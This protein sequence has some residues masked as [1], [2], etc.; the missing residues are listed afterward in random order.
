[1]LRSHQTR[2]EEDTFLGQETYSNGDLVVK[3]SNVWDVCHLTTLS[4]VEVANEQDEVIVLDCWSCLVHL[5]ARSVYQVS[6]VQGIYCL[7]SPVLESIS[8]RSRSVEFR[9]GIRQKMQLSLSVSRPIEEAKDGFTSHRIGMRTM[10]LEGIIRCCQHRKT[11]CK[12]NLHRLI[13]VGSC[14]TVAT[15]GL[16]TCWV[17]LKVVDDRVRKLMGVWRKKNWVRSERE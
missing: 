12:D 1:M 6:V 3:L 8:Y 9:L 17:L 16:K 14:E 2:N 7:K 11:S 13:L 5:K 10:A 15:S 4:K